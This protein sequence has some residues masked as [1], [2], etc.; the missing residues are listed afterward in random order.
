[1]SEMIDE[2]MLPLTL[3]VYFQGG[4]RRKENSKQCAPSR[5][6]RRDA[7]AVPEDSVDSKQSQMLR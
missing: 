7:A 1:M 2:E 5:S 4:S 3:R 6:V